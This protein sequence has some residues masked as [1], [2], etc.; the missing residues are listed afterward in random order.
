MGLRG[1]VDLND[2]CTLPVLTELGYVTPSGATAL[3]ECQL[4]AA[5]RADPG[6]RGQAPSS[7]AARLGSASHRVLELAGRGVLPDP[8]APTWTAAFETLWDDAI[9]REAARAASHPL[10]SHWSPPVR[11]RNYAMRKVATKHLARRIGERITGGGVVRHEHAQR[12]GDGRLRGKADVIRREPEH[13]IEDYKTGALYEE[14]TGELKGA[15]RTQ[16]LLYAALEREASGH[17]PARATL[18][19][20]SGDPVALQIVPAEA[21]AEAREALRALDSYNDAVRDSASA[22]E[23]ATPSSAAC[24]FCEFAVCC[25]AFW[26]AVS[27]DW[28]EDG[29]VA[30]AGTILARENAT[31]GTVALQID[32]SSGSLCR[33]EWILTRIDPER[34]KDA[35]A[36]SPGDVVAITA[37]TARDE[38]RVLRPTD[39][40]RLLAGGET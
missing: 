12:S 17:W 21:D 20:L 13:E 38:S 22:I 33:G 32:V 5:Y 14:D 3:Q 34:M 31:G 11:W 2:L 36:V 39:R 40:T 18:I 9:D 25:P 35:T 29:V 24:R 16:M 37:A 15:Y 10:E 6:F 19:P 23:L 7:Q 1:P 26:T 28:R 30:A 27:A 8:R 4:R